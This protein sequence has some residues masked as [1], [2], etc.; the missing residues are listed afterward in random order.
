M[1]RSNDDANIYLMAA[2]RLLLEQC[3]ANEHNWLPFGA[4]LCSSPGANRL[5]RSCRSVMQLALSVSFL[6]KKG[7]AVASPNSNSPAKGAERISCRALDALSL[8]HLDECRPIDAQQ[9]C[10]LLLV[11][12]CPF[13]GFLDQF[14]FEGLDRIAQIDASIGK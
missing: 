4:S 13:Q 3:S 5:R 1:D 12:A 11:P 9:L 10:S 8:Q 7:E 14:V 6:K 2:R